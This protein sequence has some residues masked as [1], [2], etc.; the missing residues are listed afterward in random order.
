MK[1]TI[2][3]ASFCL[4]VAFASQAQTDKTKPATVAPDKAAPAQTAPA[5]AAPVDNKNAAEMTFEVLEYNFGTI[6]QGESVTREFSFTNTGKE[7]LI[8][9]N[10]QGSCGCTVPVW[11]KEPVKKGAKNEIKVTFNSAGKMGMQDKTVTITSNAKNS[12]QVL[13]LKGTV[14]APAPVADPNKADAPKN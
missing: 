3:F 6:K 13:H 12:P 10:A 5:Q 4:F 8:I 14:E 2:V 9:S 7:D 1:K 11:P